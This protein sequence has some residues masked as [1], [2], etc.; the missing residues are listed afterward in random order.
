MGIPNNYVIEITELKMKKIC[1]N[2]LVNSS[3]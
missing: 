1:Q 2:M 3:V